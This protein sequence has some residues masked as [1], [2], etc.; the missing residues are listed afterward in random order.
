MAEESLGEVSVRGK[1]R[2]Q[3]IVK[4]FGSGGTEDALNQRQSVGAKYQLGAKTLRP[5]WIA[6]VAVVSA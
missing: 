2:I 5:E 1:N 4:G 3:T 6:K